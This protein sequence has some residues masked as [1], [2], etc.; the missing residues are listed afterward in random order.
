MPL[1]ETVY[2]ENVEPK[3]VQSDMQR[4]RIQGTTPGGH[5]KTCPTCKQEIKE[6]E[7]RCACGVLIGALN[8][9]NLD[10]AVE[11]HKQKCSQNRHVKA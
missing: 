10:K 9:A 6:Y 5:M 3:D 11:R 8:Q 1:R 2:P 4:Q 7:Y